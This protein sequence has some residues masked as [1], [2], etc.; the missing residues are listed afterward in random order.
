MRP[1]PR[2]SPEYLCLSDLRPGDMLH[3]I[4][5]PRIPPPV[6]GYILIYLWPH[7]DQP[8]RSWEIGVFLNQRGDIHYECVLYL[9]RA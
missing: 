8:V 7:D 4:D 6:A 2:G 1:P 5:S 3:Y 9:V